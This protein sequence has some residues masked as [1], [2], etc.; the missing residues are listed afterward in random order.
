MLTEDEK[1]KLLNQTLKED[2]QTKLLNHM[3]KEDQQTKL[4]NHMLTEDEKTKFLNHMFKEDEQTK[5][6]NHM[7]KED[8]QTQLLNHMLKED[9]QTKLL[10][11][12][13]TEDDQTKLLNHM[14][15]E[16]QQTKLLNHMIVE[17][18]ACM[19]LV[20]LTLETGEISPT[21][22]AGEISAGWAG[23]PSTHL[24]VATAPPLGATSLVSTLTGTCRGVAGLHSYIETFPSTSANVRLLSQPRYNTAWTFRF[25]RAF[26]PHRPNCSRDKYGHYD[27]MNTRRIFR[28]SYFVDYLKDVRF[29]SALGHVYVTKTGNRLKPVT[30]SKSS[31]IKMTFCRKRRTF[32]PS[33]RCPVSP[34]DSEMCP[35]SIDQPH[36]V[37][38]PIRVIRLSTNYANGLGIVIEFRGNG[39]A[40]TWRESGK[41]FSTPPPPVHP[42]EIR[43]SI[44][45]SSAVEQVNTT[46]ALA[47]YATEAGENFKCSVE[48]Y[49]TAA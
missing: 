38:L 48:T 45:P 24:K 33:R 10:N 16:D 12:M 13:L 43:T 7:L 14:L 21:F 17:E 25:D 29:C 42:T 32:N 15:K 31:E 37:L 34:V 22:G 27:R 46:S 28:S 19:F 49:V 30:F 9:E 20:S 26:E 18:N 41:P 39:P 44:Y 4:L 6:L 8:Q 5:L 36:H 2:Q 23:P 35:L 11:H 1:T 3:L 40:F 47:N